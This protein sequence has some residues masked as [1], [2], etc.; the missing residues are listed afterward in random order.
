MMEMSRIQSIRDC[1]FHDVILDVMDSLVHSF[2]H[3]YNWLGN[4]EIPS[5]RTARDP[6]GQESITDAHFLDVMVD[7]GGDSSRN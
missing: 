2:I 7:S 5:V 6:R 3:G 1:H 4:Q